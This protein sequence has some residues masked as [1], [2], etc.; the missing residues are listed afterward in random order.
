MKRLS[1]RE[2]EFIIDGEDHTMG[3]LLQH[4]LQRDERVV[5]AYYSLVH[6]LERKIKV[7]IKLSG[8]TDPIS[9]LADALNRII[10]ESRELKNRVLE[11]YSQAGIEVED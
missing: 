4:Y 6:P 1:E 9:V 3:S 10:K 11:A 7:Y 2:Y 5:N 8:S